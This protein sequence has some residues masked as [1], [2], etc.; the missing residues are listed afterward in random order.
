[1][2]GILRG[3]C[4]NVIHVFNF[5]IFLPAKVI[6]RHAAVACNRQYQ[7]DYYLCPDCKSNCWLSIDWYWP[8][9]ELLTLTL[10]FLCGKLNILQPFIAHCIQFGLEGRGCNNNKWCDRSGTILGAF[11]VWGCLLWL[12]MIYPRGK[13]KIFGLLFML[14]SIMLWN[15][16]YPMVI[17]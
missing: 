9:I 12:F 5:E 15:I 13:L 1:M 7:T 2:F 8:V 17:P 3:N 4:G 16:S 10:T 11:F 14:L 6:P